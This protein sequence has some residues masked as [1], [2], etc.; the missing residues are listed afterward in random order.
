[1]SVRDYLAGAFSLAA[2][3]LLK[4]WVIPTGVR[5]PQSAQFSP[6]LTPAAFPELLAYSLIVLG[7]ISMGFTLLGAAQPQF[8]DVELGEAMSVRSS[9][10]RAVLLFAAITGYLVGLYVLGFIL[11]TVILLVGFLRLAGKQSWFRSLL[12]AVGTTGVIIL[13]FSTLLNAPLPQ[14]IIFDW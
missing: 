1:M 3:L 5:I 13:L 14:G 11:S 7:I 4:F 8:E 9:T 6:G 10:R 12:I 2:G